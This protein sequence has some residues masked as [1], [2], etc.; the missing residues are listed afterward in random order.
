MKKKFQLFGQ[1]YFHCDAAIVWMSKS[2]YIP[3]F[4]KTPLHCAAMG[5]LLKLIGNLL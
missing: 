2:D 1:N 5:Q 4:A 3:D